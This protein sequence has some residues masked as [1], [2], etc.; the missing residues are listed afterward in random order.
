MAQL[1]RA[2]P[3]HGGAAVFAIGSLLSSKII[4]A[5]KY[6]KLLD[7]ET[8]SF[9]NDIKEVSY[10]QIPILDKDS[11]ETIGNR[12]MGTMVDLVSQFEVNDMYTQINYKNKPWFMI[13]AERKK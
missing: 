10:D 1:V 11:A 8:R 5:S 3:C 4:K 12:V 6:Q 13:M 9:K 2:P 7:V